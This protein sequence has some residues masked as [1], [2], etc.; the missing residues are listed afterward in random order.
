MYQLV[1]EFYWLLHP[2]LIPLLLPRLLPLLLP[3]F[4]PRLRNDIRGGARPDTNIGVAVLVACCL[5][6]LKE[7]H[8]TGING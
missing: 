4:L 5:T 3:L 8:H 6:F 1:C 2:L 7:I